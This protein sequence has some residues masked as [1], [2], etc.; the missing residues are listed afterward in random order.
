MP[1]FGEQLQRSGSARSGQPGITFCL[2]GW[3]L[4]QCVAAAP[5]FQEVQ[6]R[7]LGDQRMVIKIKINK[8]EG[9]IRFSSRNVVYFGSW[10]KPGKNVL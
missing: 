1:D 8:K 6:L 10:S 9:R 5:W 7:I 4:W 3:K 2:Y